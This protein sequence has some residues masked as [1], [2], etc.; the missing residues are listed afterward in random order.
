MAGIDG[1]NENESHMSTTLGIT[2][3]CRDDCS[4]QFSICTTDEQILGDEVYHRLTTDRVLG[5]DSAGNYTPDAASFGDDVRKLAG[6]ALSDSAVAALG[7][8]YSLMLQRSGRIE[9]ADVTV[10]RGDSTSGEVDLYFAVDVVSSTALPF[11][12]LFRL[13]GTTFVN[14]GV[15]QGGS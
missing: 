2:Y 10:T 8:R 13:T 15:S 12:F 14:V 6:A 5:F 11:A 1:R 7:Q 4:P 3:A 9:T